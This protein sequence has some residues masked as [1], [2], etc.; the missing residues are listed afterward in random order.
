MLD[1]PGMR[2]L[3]LNDDAEGVS[4][5]FD[6]IEAVML[7]CKFSNC[8]HAGDKGCA[9]E[10]AIQDGQLDERRWRNYQKLIREAEQAS[11]TKAQRKKAREQWGKDIAKY[12]REIKK[13]RAGV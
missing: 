4:E 13:G 12:S 1:T 3:R 11:L 9:V 2:E 8:H 5:L 7:N 6:D 10:A